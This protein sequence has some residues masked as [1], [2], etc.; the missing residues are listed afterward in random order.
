MYPTMATS[1][2]RVSTPATSTVRREAVSIDVAAELLDVSAK[3]VWR[4]V[5]AGKLRGFRV[6]R[7]W[8]IRRDVLARY[9]E[10]R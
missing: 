1:H 8:R 10:S 5:K 3:T 4:L 6:G 2:D 9:S 7:L